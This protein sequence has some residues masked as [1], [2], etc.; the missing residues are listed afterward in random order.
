MDAAIKLLEGDE[1]CD[2]CHIKG[3]NPGAGLSKGMRRIPCLSLGK[4]KKCIPCA[5]IGR[6]CKRERQSSP[7]STSRSRAIP[8]PAVLTPAG[9]NP[10]TTTPAAAIENAV[11]TGGATITTTATKAT[12]DG[13]PQAGPSSAR[14]HQSS[15]C[16]EEV[17]WLKKRLVRKM[18]ESWE[19]FNRSLEDIHPGGRSGDAVEDTL[20][21][22]ARELQE[23]LRDT[24][25]LL[26]E[27]KKGQS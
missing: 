3:K 22:M 9:I 25:E 7:D 27:V 17:T 24:E 12:N 20:K 18:R 26:K 23:R 16:A 15:V 5:L 4:D 19:F 6:P 14:A 21:E 8:T 1:Q 11:P 10:G 13:P 2:D